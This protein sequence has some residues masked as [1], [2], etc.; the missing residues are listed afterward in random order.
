MIF[1]K[2]DNLTEAQMFQAFYI[3]N[4]FASFSFYILYFV[5][6]VTFAARPQ[7]S[8]TKEVQMVIGSDVSSPIN[9]TI[10]LTPCSLKNVSTHQ[11]LSCSSVMTFGSSVPAWRHCPRGRS[12]LWTRKRSSSRRVRRR[13]R[14]WEG[15]KT[16]FS[17]WAK[18][19]GPQ[20]L[21]KDLRLVYK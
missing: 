20:L 19:E 9:A 17:I 13:W 16:Q 21:V 5:T 12:K 6:W 8:W 11:F 18:P 15:F 1:G 2:P 14:K 10:L 4:L 3:L 7:N